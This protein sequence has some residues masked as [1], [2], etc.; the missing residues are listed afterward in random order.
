MLEIRKLAAKKNQKGVASIIVVTILIVLLSLISV[1]FAKLMSRTVN[2]SSN[3]QQNSAAYYAAQ[4][5]INEITSLIKKR[6]I[7]LP[8]TYTNSCA[9]LSGLLTQDL[10]DD[11]VTTY[12]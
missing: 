9:D 4:S 8:T 10:S 5:G 3:R 1:G 7:G 2:N 11:G 6:I 12:S